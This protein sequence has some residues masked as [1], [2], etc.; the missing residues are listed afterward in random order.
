[1]SRKDILLNKIDQMFTNDSFL[2]QEVI[3][4]QEQDQTKNNLLKAEET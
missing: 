1:M 4:N 3:L 2:I